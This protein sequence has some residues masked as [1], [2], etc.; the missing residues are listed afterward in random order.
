MTYHFHGSPAYYAALW[1]LP[2]IRTE[3]L[4][5]CVTLLA[6]PK[7]TNVLYLFFKPWPGTIPVR[8]SLA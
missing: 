5:P 1:T 4:R 7:Q 3:N 8:L 2:P 6:Q